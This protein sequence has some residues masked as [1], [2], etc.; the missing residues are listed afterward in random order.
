[1]L[2]DMLANNPLMV[3]AL[4]ERWAA[5]TQNIEYLEEVVARGREGKGM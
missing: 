3:E 5:V 2:A 4:K 1:M